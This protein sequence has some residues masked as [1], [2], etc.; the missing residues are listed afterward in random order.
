M[1]STKKKLLCEQ[2]LCTELFYSNF[3]FNENF[4]SRKPRRTSEQNVARADGRGH[5]PSVQMM[6]QNKAAAHFKAHK[7]LHLKEQ[8]RLEE[9]LSFHYSLCMN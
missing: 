1:R 2:I 8:R 5:D 7:H 9:Y 3:Y 6:S 4:F